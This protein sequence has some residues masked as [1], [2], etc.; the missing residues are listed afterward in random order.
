M[1]PD[2]HENHVPYQPGWYTLFM[3]STSVWHCDIHDEVKIFPFC[4]LYQF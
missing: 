1:L 4:H 2:T 3:V